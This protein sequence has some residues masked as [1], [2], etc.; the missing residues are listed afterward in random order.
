MCTGNYKMQ[1]SFK[2]GYT[3][4]VPSSKEYVSSYEYMS[5]EL[6][7]EMWIMIRA[8]NTHVAHKQGAPAWCGWY[9]NGRP[10]FEEWILNGVRGRSAGP[11]A[12]RWNE[13][14]T[15]ASQEW[16]ING[17]LILRKSY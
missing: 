7:C 6:Q 17:K 8:D 9:P 14:G 16:W 13:D 1:T 11:S 3:A 12:T 15:I 4:I 10:K 5:G 2:P